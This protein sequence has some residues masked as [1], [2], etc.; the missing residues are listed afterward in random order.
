VKPHSPPLVG[1]LT[2]FTLGFYGIHWF[3]QKREMLEESGLAVPSLWLFGFVFTLLPADFIASLALQTKLVEQAAQIERITLWA[4]LGVLMLAALLYMRWAL[5]YNRVLSAATMGMVSSA[6]VCL[7]FGLGLLGFMSLQAK[8][9]SFL[10]HGAASPAA[11]N[12]AATEL[13]PVTGLVQ[14]P[15]TNTGDDWQQ[16][17]ATLQPSASAAAAEP[18]VITPS[19]PLKQEAAPSPRPSSAP[20]ASEPIA[21]AA[22]PSPPVQ[23]PA[24]STSQETEVIIP[25]SPTQ[26][27]A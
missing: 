8:L 3:G 10:E 4:G 12:A 19:M 27:P 2:F 14:A 17:I 22:E 23:P 6:M 18:Q 7:P 11:A 9:N 21:P 13:L 24:P 15:P 20:A 25:H 1:L 16:G 26:P 5:H